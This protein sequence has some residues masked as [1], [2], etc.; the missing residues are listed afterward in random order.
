MVLQMIMQVILIKISEKS[1]FSGI[2]I[3]FWHHRPA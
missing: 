3:T 1:P 2:V